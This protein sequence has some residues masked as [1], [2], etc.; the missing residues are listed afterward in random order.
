MSIFNSLLNWYKKLKQILEDSN[1]SLT[2]R[3]LNGVD[4][5]YQISIELDRIDHINRLPYMVSKEIIVVTEDDLVGVA[6]IKDYA[7]FDCS[8]LQNATIPNS[9]TDIRYGAFEGCSSLS[10]IYLKSIIPPS[11]SSSNAI[12]T[13]TT[14]HVPVGSGEAYRNATNWSY[15]SDKIAEDI[16]IQ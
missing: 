9:V 13:T 8:K 7:F 16:V 14:I 12:P 4:N 3:G 6:V 10:N 15:H 11:L 5:L 1:I 2:N